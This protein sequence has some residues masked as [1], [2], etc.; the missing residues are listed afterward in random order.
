MRVDGD[1]RLAFVAEFTPR[2]P[3]EIREG[4][5]ARSLAA[6]DG[7]RE[8]KAVPGRAHDRLRRAAD[9][10]PDRQLLLHGPRPHTGVLEGRAMLALPRHALLVADRNQQLELLLEQLVVVVEVVPE[11]R[12][13]LD[14]RTAAG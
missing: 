9:G 6:D 7:E 12:E 4:C 2:A 3:I 8:R 14:E 10:D 5:K 11:E 1:A 13:R